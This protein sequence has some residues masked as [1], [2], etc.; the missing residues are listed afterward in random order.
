MR[1]KGEGDGDGDFKATDIGL[2]VRL[3]TRLNINQVVKIGAEGL[4][5]SQD[6]GVDNGGECQGFIGQKG[7]QVVGCNLPRHLKIG[8]RIVASMWDEAEDFEA[9]VELIIVLCEASA[10]GAVVTYAESWLRGVQRV[11]HGHEKLGRGCCGNDA[12][13]KFAIDRC[14]LTGNLVIQPCSRAANDLGI[15][16]HAFFNGDRRAGIFLLGRKMPG[17]NLI[18]V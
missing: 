9:E 11:A 12:G 8:A 7:H 17:G 1:F 18:C 4:H 5:V 15:S 16:C 10:L 13:R 2:A 6:S 14:E 3:L